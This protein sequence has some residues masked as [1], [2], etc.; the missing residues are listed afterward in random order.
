MT[1]FYVTFINLYVY[2]LDMLKRSKSFKTKAEAKTYA[3]NCRKRGFNAR[4]M[5][6]SG[7]RVTNKYA[8]FTEKR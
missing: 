4:V 2:D 3:S 8:V 7:P 1:L 6:Q 5:E